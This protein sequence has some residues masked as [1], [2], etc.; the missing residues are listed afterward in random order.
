MSCTLGKQS[1]RSPYCCGIVGRPETDLRSYLRADNSDN[2][3][4]PT[5]DYLPLAD[6]FFTPLKKPQ[7]L[8]SR[9]NL[10]IIT[11]PHSPIGEISAW[12]LQDFMVNYNDLAIIFVKGIRGGRLWG[13]RRSGIAS[14]ASTLFLQHQHVRHH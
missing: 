7:K 4:H 9:C 14:F 11:N 3:G 5:T 8:I 13:D 2:V 6:Y 1:E 12:I 10:T